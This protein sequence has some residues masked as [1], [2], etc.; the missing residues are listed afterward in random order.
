MAGKKK[1]RTLDYELAHKLARMSCTNEEIS[2]C[3]NVSASYFYDLLKRDPEL[4]DMIQKGRAEG[5]ASLRRVQWQKALEGNVTM[6][7]WLGKQLL[8][9]HDMSRTEVTGKDGEAIQIEDQASAARDIIEAA[10]A[11]HNQQRG[12]GSDL[13]TADPETAH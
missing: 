5:R 7:I 1:A 11:R 4:S 9:Q 2:A 10:I 3:L 13:G 6:L 8:G 12:T